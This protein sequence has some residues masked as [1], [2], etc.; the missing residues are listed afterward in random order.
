MSYAILPEHTYLL[1][2]KKIQKIFFLNLTKFM[3]A[4]R[5]FYT[6]H[7]YVES[8]SVTRQ[9]SALQLVKV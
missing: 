5:A 1:L 4:N 6:E 3:P 8:F 7:K 2:K 9:V